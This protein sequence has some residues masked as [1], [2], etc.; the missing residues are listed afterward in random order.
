LDIFFLSTL[1]ASAAFAAGAYLGL[2]EDVER[3]GEP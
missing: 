2:I 3:L 1:I